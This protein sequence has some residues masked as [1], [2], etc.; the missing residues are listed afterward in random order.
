[1][2]AIIG[3]HFYFYIVIK[4]HKKFKYAFVNKKVVAKVTL[5]ARGPR[6]RR[7]PHARAANQIA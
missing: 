6:Y 2:T 5:L 1:M 7:K 4:L 3:E